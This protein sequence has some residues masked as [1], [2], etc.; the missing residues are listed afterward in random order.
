MKNQV[1][2]LTQIANEL[3]SL[4]RMGQGAV[5]RSRLVEFQRA[6]LPRAIICEFAHLARRV[7]LPWLGVCW[8]NPIVRPE[9]PGQQPATSTEQAAY[10]SVLTRMGFTA[11]A[12]ALLEQI[13]GDDL[14][15]VWLYQALAY[16][17]RW[18]YRKAIP[19]LKKYLRTRNLDSYQKLL[20]QVNLA[21]AYIAVDNHHS[22]EVLLTELRE[23]T[24]GQQ[25]LHGNTLELS[26]QTAILQG[27]YGLAQA[28][29]RDGESRLSSHGGPSELHL[30]KWRALLKLFMYGPGSESQQEILKVRQRALQIQSYETV[31]DCDYFWS[32]YKRDPH[33][34]THVY[35]G[36]PFLT[37]RKRM[38]QP[39][40]SWIH[41]PA[42]YHWDP[43]HFHPAPLTPDFDLTMGRSLLDSTVCIG[44]EE[45]LA[46]LLQVFCSDFYRRPSLWRVF[47]E[48]YSG[49]HFNPW[50]SPGRVYRLIQRFRVWCQKHEL[51]W[52]VSVKNSEVFFRST[53]CYTVSVTAEKTYLQKSSQNLNIIQ[54][55]FRDSS[56]TT[57]QAAQVLNLSSR[58]THRIL[59]EGLEKNILE[60]FGRGAATL[61]RVA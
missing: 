16:M 8:L 1:E 32:L 40:Q 48:V 58:T 37:Y 56:F 12:L 28:Y 9:F 18:E 54:D 46:R 29:L 39:R 34:F 6:Q 10:A 57:Y 22:A 51:P 15:E 61:Y 47:A 31:R 21:S 36:T 5:V 44:D 11:E 13:S 55:R 3:D 53:S 24:V 50:T 41:L 2:E 38:V 26:A 60:K 33:L 49:E 4:I 19:S 45:L 43:G 35:F 42:H 7:N 20:A 17:G 59:K 30:Q 52:T 14:P 23:Q 25:L 27:E